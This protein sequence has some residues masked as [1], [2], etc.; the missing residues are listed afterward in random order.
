MNLE[1]SKPRENNNGF[2]KLEKAGLWQNYLKG[3]FHDS[4][5]E[6]SENWIQSN[7]IV[8]SNNALGN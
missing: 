6:N 5:C 3:T 4:K 7:F 1:H 2:Q 8:V